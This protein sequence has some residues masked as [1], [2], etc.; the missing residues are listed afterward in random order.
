MPYKDPEKRKAFDK[1]Y[2]KARY[3]EQLVAAAGY[4]RRKRVNG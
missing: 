3:A 2:R 4:L 1:A